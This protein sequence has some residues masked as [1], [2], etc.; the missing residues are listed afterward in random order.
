MN[1]HVTPVP[2]GA[3]VCD[4]DPYSMESLADLEAWHRQLLDAGPIVWIPLYGF[5]AVGRHEVCSKVFSNWKL[6]CSSRGV[7]IED[8]TTS[9]PWRKPSIILEAD[10]P[11]HTNAKKAMMRALSRDTVAGL[12]PGFR[13]YAEV[14]VTRLLEMDSFDIAHDFA[15]DFPLKVFPDAIGMPSENR[16]RMLPYAS[17]AF[18]AAGPDNDIRRTALQNALPVIPWAE[19]QTLRSSLVGPGLG[20]TLYQCADEG[21]I[22]EEEARLLVR[23]LISAGVDTTISGLG[24]TLRFLAENPDQWAALKDDP[25][26][27]RAA[28]EEA[29][30]KASP[31]HAFF[32]TATEDT[33]IAGQPIRAGDKIMC[34]LAAANR[35]PRKFPDPEAYDIRRDTSGH[36]AF[37]AGVHSC[38]GQ[39]IAR[40]EAEVLLGEVVA[41]VARIEI[42]E[43][44]EWRPGNALRM[45]DRGRIRFVPA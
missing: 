26:L 28:F 14:L 17:I 30:R 43:P 27:V 41:R 22:T 23:S 39:I 18:N 1:S 42:L 35:D 4:V 6:F 31:V 36:I 13:A 33:E 38:V 40:K 7:G 12:E 44:I 11:E 45:V 3:I 8:L 19:E 29:V 25:T 32:R 21:L 2:Q 20:E 16:R 34:N 37:G 5:W 9:T 10:P 15:E 24:A